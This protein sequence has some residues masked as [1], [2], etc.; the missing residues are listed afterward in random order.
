MF[1]IYCVTCIY[2]DVS[3]CLVTMSCS[4]TVIVLNVFYLLGY[5]YILRC[6]NVPGDNA[7]SQT[8]TVL[9]VFYLLCY[10]YILRC[11]S[12]PGDNVLFANCY[13]PQCFLSIVLHVYT[14]LYQCAW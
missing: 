9:N 5:M 7:R 8:V 6:I 14:S 10:M 3:V 11:I 12:V 4:Q 2:F 1:S 13:S